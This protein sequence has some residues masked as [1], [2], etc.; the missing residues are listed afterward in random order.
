[1]CLAQQVSVP[2]LHGSAFQQTDAEDVGTFQQRGKSGDTA[3]RRSSNANM[4]ASFLDAVMRSDVGEHLV[5]EE[6]GDVCALK[7]LRASIKEWVAEGRQFNIA[8]RVA[9]DAHDDDGFDLLLG[10]EAG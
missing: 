9:I 10:D 6:L 5:C 3:E 1:M 8:V 2:V 4:F 7:D